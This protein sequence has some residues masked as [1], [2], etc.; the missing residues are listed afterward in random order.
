VVKIKVLPDGKIL[1]SEKEGKIIEILRD[2]GIKPDTVIVFKG[3]NPVP[4]NDKVN[5]DEQISVLKVVSLG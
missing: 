5:K 3:K 4:V 2:L 1:E